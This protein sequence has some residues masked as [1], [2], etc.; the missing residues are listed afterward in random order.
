MEPNNGISLKTVNEIHI[1]RLHHF[2]NLEVLS[3]SKLMKH[4]AKNFKFYDWSWTR[5]SLHDYEEI[6]QETNLIVN[7]GHWS[8]NGHKNFS[9][10]V[11]KNLGYE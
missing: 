5:L 8:E 9:Q 4:S 1:N 7:D 11:L 10:G 6:R 2:Y 3:W